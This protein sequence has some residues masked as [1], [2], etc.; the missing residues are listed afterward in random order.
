MIIHGGL[1]SSSNSCLVPLDIVPLVYTH[2]HGGARRSPTLEG[3]CRAVQ[4]MQYERASLG[5]SSPP[6]LMFFSRSRGACLSRARPDLYYGLPTATRG[7]SGWHMLQVRG[8]QVTHS[9]GASIAHDNSNNSRPN[10]FS[11]IFVVHSRA[12]KPNVPGE[13][14]L[15]HITHG[16]Q[17]G[18]VT[19]RQVGSR[20]PMG[21]QLQVYAGGSPTSL[22]GRIALQS[23]VSCSGNFWRGKR[24]SQSR[25]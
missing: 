7:R 5:C 23:M 19:I 12:K 10:N 13:P 18:Y 14:T 1:A 15:Q 2:A 20:T 17:P 21:A 25:R 16:A 9:P 4:V 22:A 8:D 11:I 6:D 3:L 24:R